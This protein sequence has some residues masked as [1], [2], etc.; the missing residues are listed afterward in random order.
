MVGGEGQAKFSVGTVSEQGEGQTSGD[1]DEVMFVLNIS[2]GGEKALLMLI[3][4]VYS[5][6]KQLF[7]KSKLMMYIETVR[8]R[9]DYIIKNFCLYFS[10]KISRWNL[11]N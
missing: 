10:M 8:K 5:N 1:E 6:V 11:S 7:L 2:F 3:I 4:L 9:S